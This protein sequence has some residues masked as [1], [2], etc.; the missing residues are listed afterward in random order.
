MNLTTINGT[1]NQPNR[2]NI[3]NTTQSPS[4]MITQQLLGENKRIKKGN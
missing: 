2:S 3:M 4:G 1:L